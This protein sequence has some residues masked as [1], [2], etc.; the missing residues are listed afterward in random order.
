VYLRR[1]S[2]SRFQ[3]KRRGSHQR[4]RVHVRF[5]PLG[6]AVPFSV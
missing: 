5:V 4:L 2:R 1:R 3:G 6:Q